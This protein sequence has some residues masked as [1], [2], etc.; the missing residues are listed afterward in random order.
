MAYKVLCIEDN[1]NHARIVRKILNS[2]GYDVVM[3]RDG[4][5]GVAM[6][7]REKPDLILLDMHLPDMTGESVISCLRGDRSTVSSIPIIAVTASSDSDLHDRI[8][9]AGCDD[10]VH[11]PYTKN[12]LLAAVRRCTA[13]RTAV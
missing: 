9:A 6:A 12:D 11:K 13:A 5:Q 8:V 4:L 10:F 7:A 1:P 3:S 2:R